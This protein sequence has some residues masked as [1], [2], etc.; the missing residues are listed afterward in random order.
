[1]LDFFEN[2]ASISKIYRRP[3]SNANC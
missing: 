2:I 1:M 3:I